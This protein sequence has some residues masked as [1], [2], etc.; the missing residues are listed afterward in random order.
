MDRHA[1]LKHTK[2]QQSSAAPPLQNA[3]WIFVCCCVLLVVLVH[4]KKNSNCYAVG[5]GSRPR[6]LPRIIIRACSQ[7]RDGGRDGP[8]STDTT[9]AT[10]SVGTSTSSQWGYFKSKSGLFFSFS[11][12]QTCPFKNKINDHGQH[13]HTEDIVNSIR[14][15]CNL[16]INNNC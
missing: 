5:C 13:N 15:H 1:T 12:R 9:I 3:Y 10:S 6:T 2:Y 14:Y 7:P 16:F 4:A 8:I 11:A